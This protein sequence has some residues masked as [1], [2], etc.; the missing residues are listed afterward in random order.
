MVDLLDTVEIYRQAVGSAYK[1]FREYDLKS[2]A[3]RA[4]RVRRRQINTIEDDLNGE[5]TNSAISDAPPSTISNL[6]QADATWVVLQGDGGHTL[7]SVPTEHLR[8]P[9]RLPTCPS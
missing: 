4:R 2:L 7:S 9:A 6:L 8:R 5:N 3:D 1:G